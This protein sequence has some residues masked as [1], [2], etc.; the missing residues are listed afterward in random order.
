[1]II[2]PVKRLS[3]EMTVPGDKSI[4]HRAV[5]AGAIAGGRTIISN[6]QDSDDCRHTIRA[7]REMGVKILKGGGVTT[8]EGKGLYGL[9][10]P[11]APIFA[12]N[13]GTTMRIMAGIL[14]AQAFGSTIAGD[15]QLSGRPMKRVAEPLAAMGARITLKDGQFPP[16]D[17][18]PGNIHPI[19]HEMTVPS[20][21]VKSAIL[22]AGLYADGLTSVVEEFKSRD[23]TERMLKH[24]GAAVTVRGFK[25]SVRGVRELRARRVE[26][27]GDISSASFFMAAA[28]IVKG[29]RVRIGGVGINP[30]RAGIINV[31]KRMGAKVSVMNRTDGFEPAADIEVAGSGLKGI[32]I[33]EREIPSL[34]DELPV[35]F[36]A[37]SLAA[38]RTTIEGAGEL[39]VK[40]TDRIRSMKEGL[41]AMGGRIRVS[42]DRIVIDGVEKLNGSR[43]KSFD[44]HRTCMALAVAALGAAGDSEIDDVA[45]VS[46][47]FPKFFDKLNMLKKD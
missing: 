45:C 34:I 42:G 15:S 32:V 30:T 21:Q 47:S 38:G 28:A 29:S 12:G 33:R 36:V 1:M 16:I 10:R 7:F 13:S 14:S 2:R 23:H 8:V 24:F 11:V 17:I 19:E 35:I 20:A 31:L 43:L 5:M 41:E 22:F 9:K 25:V 26:V 6:I 44:D 39:R 46:K 4:S 18:K 27:P 3:G 40:E 37:A